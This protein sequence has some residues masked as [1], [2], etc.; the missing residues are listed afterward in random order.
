MH[1]VLWLLPLVGAKLPPTA[2]EDVSAAHARSLP[3]RHALLVL[4]EDK[5]AAKQNARARAVLSRINSRAENRER[6]EFMAVA[7]LE[8]WNWWPAKRY[9]Y[10]DLEKIAHEKNTRLYADWTGALRRAWGLAAH[11]STVILSDSGGAVLFAAEGTLSDGDIDK[12]V[13]ALEALGCD[14]K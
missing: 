10:K 2:V 6:F 5:E 13:A 1:F 8:K 14:V 7:D 9:V 3:D 4:Y 12:M 11:K